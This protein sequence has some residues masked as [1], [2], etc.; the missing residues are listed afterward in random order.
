M[1]LLNPECEHEVEGHKLAREVQML[2]SA[3]HVAE[4]AGDQAA[5]S[6]LEADKYTAIDKLDA[7]ILRHR[8]ECN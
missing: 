3:Q 8:A 6:D 7:N 5:A 1:S 4:Y 2:A